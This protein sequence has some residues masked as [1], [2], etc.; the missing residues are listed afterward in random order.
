MSSMKL[1]CG[2]SDCGLFYLGRFCQEFI[3]VNLPENGSYLIEAVDVWEMKRDVIEERAAGNIRVKLS[4]K[5]GIAILVTR[6][7]G[8]KL[9]SPIV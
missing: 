1:C 4:G 6:I 7:S 8:D 5:E 9:D 3:D 2:N